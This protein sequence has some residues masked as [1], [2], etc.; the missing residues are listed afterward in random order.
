MN[1]ITANPLAL[2]T[3]SATAL[4]TKTFTVFMIRWVGPGAVAG[5]QSSVTN[6]AGTTIWATVASGSNYV[7]ES[8]YEEK[9]LVFE[10][11]KVPVLDAGTLY[12]YVYSAV[13][14]PT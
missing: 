2:D 6:N 9:P 5:N 8:H 3:V 11:L 7:E 14:I 10:G 13:P 1:N 4:T 12:L